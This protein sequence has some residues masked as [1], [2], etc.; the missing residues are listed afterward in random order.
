MA[1]RTSK[2][3]M[4]AAAGG[5]L[6]LGAPA[7]AAEPLAGHFPIVELRQYTL[8]TGK[9]DTLINLF[10][11]EFIESQEALGIKVIGTFTDLDR[12]DRFV[13]LRGFR[14]MDSRLEGLTAFYGGPVWQAHRGEANATMIDSDNVLLLR[15]PTGPGFRISGDR[16][17]R[18]KKASSGLIVATIYYL[19]TPPAEALPLFET[20]VKP[21]LDKAGIPLLAWFAPEAASNNYPRLPVREGER[22]LVSF[23]RFRSVE[24]Y[25][26]HE[27]AIAEA[28]QPMKSLLERPPEV[29]RLRPTSRSEL[30]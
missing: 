19:R 1:G 11:R 14:D 29:L 12:P 3:Q 30:R 22:V 13:W 17:A 6:G 20:Q 15:A 4:I 8:H 5:L 28:Q 25:A 26:A 7:S 21:R 23:A 10:E 24:D 16:P 18:G 9:R 27:P 2:A